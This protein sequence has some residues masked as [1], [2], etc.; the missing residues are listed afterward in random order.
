MSERFIVV[1]SH[2]HLDHIAGTAAFADSEVI[3]NERTAEL[4][5]RNQAAIEA[6]SHEGPPAIDPLVLPTRVFAG[7]ERLASAGTRSS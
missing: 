3:A 2:W 4:M 6:G 5:E 7:R 1:L